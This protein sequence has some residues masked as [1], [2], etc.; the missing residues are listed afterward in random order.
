M[1]DDERR[2]FQSRIVDV[3]NDETLT[4]RDRLF[5][6]TDVMLAF[7]D[8]VIRNSPPT[9]SPAQRA[10]E[11]FGQIDADQ[12]EGVGTDYPMQ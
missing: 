10:A 7:M 5:I 12:R 4:S 11:W 8:I 6:I 1:T 2:L 9:S 3:L